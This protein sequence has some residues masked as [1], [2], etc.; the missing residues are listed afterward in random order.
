MCTLYNTFPL[1]V[2]LRQYHHSSFVLKELECVQPLPAGEWSL[3]TVPP[4]GTRVYTTPSLWRME[5]TDSTNIQALFQKF[6]S[7]HTVQPPSCC[8]LDSESTT[9][10]VL[11][12][13]FSSVYNPSPLEVGLRQYQ[14]SY[15]TAS[16]KKSSHL[17]QHTRLITIW[18]PAVIVV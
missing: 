4:L 18:V 5:F 8:R 3:L 13:R 11:F 15:C 14:C 9:I 10:Q 2:G 1:K 16:F 7:V 17:K 12:E 6:S